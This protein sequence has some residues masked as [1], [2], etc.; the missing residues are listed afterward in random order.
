MEIVAA[1][2]SAS[3]GIDPEAICQWTD[4]IEERLVELDRIFNA[5]RDQHLETLDS[6]MLDDVAMMEKR[7]KRSA[8][9]AQPIDF[10]YD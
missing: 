4:R 10:A 1:S 3:I 6:Q 9:M 7:G 5:R 2:Q 8:S